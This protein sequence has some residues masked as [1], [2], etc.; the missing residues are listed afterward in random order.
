MYAREKGF[1]LKPC[2]PEH[3]KSSSI[4]ERFMSVPVKVVY[5][6]IAK[7][8]DPKVEVHVVF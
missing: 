1:K 5:F 3:P 4:V 6:S 8:K 7:G 2:T